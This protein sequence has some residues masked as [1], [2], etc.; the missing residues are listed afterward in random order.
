MPSSANLRWTYMVRLEPAKAKREL[1]AAIAAAGG[2]IS[3]A[4]DALGMHRVTLH[5]Y[6]AMLGL[7]SREK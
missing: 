3:A 2:N 5:K 6:L 4:A 1:K 7:S